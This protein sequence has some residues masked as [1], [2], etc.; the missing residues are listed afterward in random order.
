MRFRPQQWER[1]R[2]NWR[3]YPTGGGERW[4]GF[5]A[6]RDL[7]GVPPEFLLVP[8][9]GHTFGHAGVASSTARTGS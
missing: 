9:I 7:E 2:A 5:E 8:L 3:V 6:V 1:T 4:I